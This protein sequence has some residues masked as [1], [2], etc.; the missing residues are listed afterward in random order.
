MKKTAQKINSTTQK[1]I[2]IQDITDDIVIMSGGQACLIL[3]VTATNFTLQ[4]KE[5]Q[6][7]KIISYASLLNSLSFA[8]QIVILSRKLDISSYVR[9]LEAEAQR[10]Q[11]QML[12][13]HI[14]Q[15]KNFV[16][17]LVKT[18][19]V[20][21]KSFYIIIPFSFLEKGAQA[22]TNM[23]D[24]DAFLK[25]AKVQLH[26]K[27]TSVIQELLRV[28]LKSKIL[29]ENELIQVFYE[30]YNSDSGKG[31]IAQAVNNPMVK[32]IKTKQL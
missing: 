18:N 22:I 30:I 9:Q 21:E 14:T 8:I 16:S 12:S 19:I 11:N 25:D 23:N 3:E 24:K 17:E 1:F 2:E 29:M 10:S 7:S 5:E 28:G 31:D 13:K 6:E 32:G 26:S 15:Y 27:S 4:S 20:L